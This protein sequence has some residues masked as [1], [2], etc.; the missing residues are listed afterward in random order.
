MNNMPMLFT[1]ERRNVYRIN[2]LSVYWAEM[3]VD[4]M[5]TEQNETCSLFRIMDYR[6]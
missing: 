4:N 5:Y 1:K 3:S 2:V 6:D